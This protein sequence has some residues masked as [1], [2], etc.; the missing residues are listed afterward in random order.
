[1]SQFGY[2]QNYQTK[3]QGTPQYGPPSGQPDPNQYQP[4]KQGIYGLPTPPPPMAAPN[5]YGPI[6]FNPEVTEAWSNP[7][8]YVSGWTDRKS[9]V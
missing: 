7:N 5:P 4:A 2:Q 6:N 3:T 8:R 1:M 9:V